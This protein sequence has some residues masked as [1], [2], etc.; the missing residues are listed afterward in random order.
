MTLPSVISKTTLEGID[1]SA[2]TH[3]VR[4]VA[5]E[6]NNPSPYRLRCRN[7]TY[8]FEKDGTVGKHVIDIPVSVWM[9]GQGRRDMVAI[10][11]DFRTANGSAFTIQVVRIKPE[12]QAD[13]F[14]QAALEQVRRLLSNLGAPESVVEAFG[15]V[16]KRDL[17]GLKNHVSSQVDAAR[18]KPPAETKAQRQA[19]LMREAKAKKKA[20]PVPA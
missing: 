16:D 20:E 3:A 4:V 9:H 6:V 5:H 14:A 8:L 11:D 18:S 7:R 15:F 13:D 1:T 17:D 2:D 10:C 19:R 12:A